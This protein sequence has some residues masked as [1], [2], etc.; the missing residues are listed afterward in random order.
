MRAIWRLRRTEIEAGEHAGDVS[1]RR[2]AVDV[3]QQ[4]AYCRRLCRGDVL[5]VHAAFGGK[6]DQRL[7]RGDV[8]QNGGVEFARDIGLLFDQQA[9]D[10]VVADAHAEDFSG[11]IAAA[12]AGVPA[13]LMPPALPRL[14]A[15]TCAL[16]TQGPIL[17]AA[18]AASA[19]EMQTMPRGTGIPAGAR[20]NDFAACSSKFMERLSA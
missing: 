4:A 19:S 3:D 20:I 16:T 13:S 7:A 17:A 15:G 1:R 14:P 8:V 5:D 6:Q 10:R 12:S 11:G 9:L 18:I 2:L